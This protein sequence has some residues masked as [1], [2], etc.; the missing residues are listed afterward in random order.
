M[1]S[2]SVHPSAILTWA[3][4]SSEACLAGSPRIEPIHFLVAIL[5]IVDDAYQ[6]DVEELNLDPE[7]IHS[8]GDA[9]SQARAALCVSDEEV[10]EARRGLRGALMDGVSPIPVRRLHRSKASRVLFA[11]AAMRAVEESSAELTVLHLLQEL[12]DHLPEGA[13][14]DYAERKV[15]H[16]HFDTEMVS[17]RPPFEGP[18]LGPV[19]RKAGSKTPTID[20]MGRDLTALAAEGRLPKVVGRRREMTKMA[21]YLL[22]TTKNNVLVIGDAGVGK[23]AIVEGFAQRL[24]SGDVAEPLQKLRIVQLSVADLVSGTKYRGDMEARVQGIVSE[25]TQDANLVLFL[26]EIH[27]AIGAGT[28]SEAPMDV[29]NILK[30]ALSREDFRIIGATTS[31]E[32]ERHIKRD[33]A[34]L[35]R[36]QILRVSEPTKEVALQICGEWARRIEEVHKV[37][38]EQE[39]IEAAVELS[40]RLIRDRSLPD[41][42]IDLLENAATFVKVTTLSLA[43]ATMT[44]ETLSVGR[45]EIAAVLEEQHGI[46]VAASEVLDPNSVDALLRQKLVGQ[47]DVISALVET[48]TAL[49][50]RTEDREKPLAIFMFTGPTGVG[51]TYTAELMGRALFGNGDRAVGR[52]NMNEY[53]ERH[54]LARLIGAPPGFVGHEEYGA[55]FRFAETV[56]Q[57]LILLDEMEKA[58]P[59]IQD[60]FL[61]IFD[62]GQARD[63]RGRQVDFRRHLVIMTCNLVPVSGMGRKLGFRLREEDEVGQKDEQQPLQELRSYFRPEFLAR[64]DRI[65]SFRGLTA[66]DYNALFDRKLADLSD[67]MRSQRGITLEVAGEVREKLS[68]LAMEQGEGARG[69]EALFKRLL[70]APLHIHLEEVEGEAAVRVSWKEDAPA[71]SA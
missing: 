48:L 46:S 56:P 70:L 28:G 33:K 15:V 40:D 44:K 50:V 11:R 65:V 51:K 39:A 17:Q 47:D 22:R 35:R 63:S 60:Y 9:V 69:F 7:I 19:A 20:S 43:P 54:E 61:Q 42:A 14:R 59:E 18:Q 66:E 67:Q 38:I 10:T 49:D 71:F 2:I 53:K 13:M 12:L 3:L 29:G 58:H 31:D 4:A 26:D 64:I 37:K 52:F 16:P 57:G 1:R 32:Y 68:I 34:F 24:A 25:A 62:K 23:N 6:R 30:P 45:D 8:L 5:K 41:K 55:L 21:R 36:F 27:L